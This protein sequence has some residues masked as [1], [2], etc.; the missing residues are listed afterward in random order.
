[1]VDNTAHGVCLKEETVAARRR[2]GLV[3][4]LERGGGPKEACASATSTRFVEDIDAQEINGGQRGPK[5]LSKQRAV[6]NGRSSQRKLLS[7][8]GAWPG[9]G[10]LGSYPPADHNVGPRKSA[11]FTTHH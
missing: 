8:S 4:R 1:M 10:E 2:G 7:I 5:D 11:P 9:R 6:S 3:T